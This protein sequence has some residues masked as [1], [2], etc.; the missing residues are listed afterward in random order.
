[1]KTQWIHACKVLA[2]SLCCMIGHNFLEARELTSEEIFSTDRVLEVQITVA[3]KDWDTIRYHSR[4]FIPTLHESRK[5]RPIKPPY[6]YVDADVTI[7]G[8][9]FPQV[10]IRKKGFLGSQSTSR[11]SLKIKL[12]HTDKK[13]QI[14]GLTN[15]TFNNN[16]NDKSLVSQFMGYALFNAANSPA[17][18]CAYAKVTVNGTSLGIYSH[19]ETVRKPFLK[20][21]F[22]N[23][24]GTLYE[25]PY[26]DFYPGWEGSFE[27]K[28]GKDKPGRKKIKQ[29]IK[30][31]ENEDENTDQAIGELV[32]LDSFYTFWAMEGLLGLGDGYSGNK[33]NFFIYLNPDTNKFHFFPWGADSGFK[34]SG[35]D[36]LNSVKTQGL[37]AHRLYQLELGRERY[38]KTIMDII[39]KHWHKDELLAEINRIEV[40]LKPHLVQ[41]QIYGN[42]KKQKSENVFTSSLDKTRKFIRQRE[43]DITQEIANGMP[44][45]K[46]SPGKPLTIAPRK[47]GTFFLGCVIGGCA[48]CITGT[49]F[50]LAKELASWIIGLF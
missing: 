12:N 45:R 1:M 46:K 18:R 15:L 43:L 50:N 11:P 35:S 31:L 40:M 48:G 17:P 30:I 9:K 28:S 32:D 22:G 49:S 20:R 16:R 39:E 44:E 19:V 7:D 37:I 14:E 42:G 2:I 34:G 10:G 5:F 33:N 4:D 38:A 26:V 24:S 6:T 29:L 47:I 36:D 25:G 23:D 21:A 3:E 8:V 27:H 41:S 13:G